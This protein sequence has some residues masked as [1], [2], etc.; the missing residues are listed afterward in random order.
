MP[1]LLA[2]GCALLWGSADFCGGTVSRRLPSATVLLW[3]SLVA[4]PVIVT[5]MVLSGET[6]FDAHTIGW[7]AVAGLGASLGI[8][9]LYQ[10]LATG[11]M[12]VVAPI[13][14]TSVVVP[15]VYGLAT[16]ADVKALC[17]LGIAVAIV[18]VVLAG[19]PNLRDFREGGHRPV[20]L[21]LAA[22]AGIGVSL[23]AVAEGSH[24][25]AYPTLVSMRVTY[26]FVLV[27]IVLLQGARRTPDRPSIPLIV[28][29]G[30]GDI[31]AVTLYGVATHSGSLPIV[32]AISSMF[33]VTTL[34]LARQFHH[35]RL[36]REQ[37]LGVVIALIGVV[38]VV[39]TR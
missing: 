14:S 9:A 16:G 5:V 10:G 2:F 35:E 1:I 3:S 25:S 20:L 29:A 30:L 33:P 11:V 31:S 18:G 32:A 8:V 27:P 13:A 34:V 15:V 6:T 4:L 26:L 36:Q 22:A 21:A 12:G 39:T 37:L 23:V 7:G 28:L 38:I 24:E 17:G 19:G